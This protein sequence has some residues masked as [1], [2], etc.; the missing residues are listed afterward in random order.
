VMHLWRHRA[1]K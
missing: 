1:I